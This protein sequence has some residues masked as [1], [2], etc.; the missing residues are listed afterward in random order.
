[1]SQEATT[2]VTRI[3]P[4]PHVLSAM[5]PVHSM[6]NEGFRPITTYSFDE[7]VV[8]IPG[9]SWTDSWR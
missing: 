9:L 7:A 6:V 1:M 8:H 4:A 3:A 5:F 2:L